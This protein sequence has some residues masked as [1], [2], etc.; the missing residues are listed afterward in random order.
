MLDVVCTGVTPR[1]D[2][3]TVTEI[4]A[5]YERVGATWWLEAIAPYR[6]GQ[7]FEGEW[8]VA[9]LRERVLQGPPTDRT[10]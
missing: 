4:V 3:E 2:P 5:A 7:G 10:G 1:D 8:P 6:F 9:L